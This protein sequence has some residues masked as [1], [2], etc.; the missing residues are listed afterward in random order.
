MISKP[1]LRATG[2]RETRPPP[3]YWLTWTAPRDTMSLAG[4]GRDR[5]TQARARGAGE[6]GPQ[7]S[8]P[9]A[10]CAA[11][12]PKATAGFFSGGR[13]AAD[14]GRWRPRSGPG[15][16]RLSGSR[17]SE[18]GARY[19]RSRYLAATPPLGGGGSRQRGR[20]QKKQGE[21]P[22]GPM[23]QRR[24]RERRTARRRSHGYGAR[25]RA[26]YAERASPSHSALLA[27][28]PALQ[29]SPVG[30]TVRPAAPGPRP[31]SRAGRPTAAC[32]GLAV[33]GPA[34]GRA[35]C[36][37]PCLADRVKQARGCEI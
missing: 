24:L 2:G 20:E 26:W 31:P 6:R 14:L 28:S 35:G 33:E 17:Y 27:A 30:A 23:G 16:R 25:Q 4:D 8:G 12:R 13:A 5:G 1:A 36:G 34:G 32:A 21:G 22:Q 29:A 9:D 11:R 15:G 37:R 18:R 19:V 10:T 3:A 7:I